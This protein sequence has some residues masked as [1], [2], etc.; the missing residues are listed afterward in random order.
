MTLNIEEGAREQGQANF[1]STRQQNCL[2]QVVK[3]IVNKKNLL[4]FKD[5]ILQKLE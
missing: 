2:A 5:I 4:K 3:K 1:I